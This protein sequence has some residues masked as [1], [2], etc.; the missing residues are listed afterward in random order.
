MM[1]FFNR[2][3]AG[4]CWGRWAESGLMLGWSAGSWIVGAKGGLLQCWSVGSECGT[5]L[6][7]QGRRGSAR[8]SPVVAP[9]PKSVPGLIREKIDCLEGECVTYVCV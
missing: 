8:D 9:M 6:Q 3:W 5:S 2:N 4:A 7:K 1:P